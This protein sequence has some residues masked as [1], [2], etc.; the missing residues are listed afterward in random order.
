M[1]RNEFQTPNK[2][3]PIAWLV[4]ILVGILL[5]VISQDPLLVFISVL[6]LPIIFYFSFRDNEPQVIFIAFIFYYLSITI[7]L[8]Y[9]IYFN[10]SFTLYS[11]STLIESTTYISFVAMF[12]FMLGVYISTK[13]IKFKKND[14]ISTTLLKYNPSRIVIIYLSSFLLSSFIRINGSGWGGYY[15][16]AVNITYLHYAILFV[17][18]AH[19]YYTDSNTKITIA[20]VLFEIILSF[21]GYFSG[22]KDYLLIILA[23]LLAFKIQF[24]FRQT[25]LIT[26]ISFLTLYTLII[27][28]AVKPE[29]RK[30]LNG[31]EKS[32]TV[33]VSKSDALGK[34][35]ELASNFNSKNYNYEEIYYLLV[36]RISYTEFF[37]LSMEQVPQFI[38]HEN[39]QL[40]LDAFD[41]VLTPRILNPNKKAINDSEMVNK[42]SGKRV[43]G[44][45]EG[46]SFSLGIVAEMYIDFGIYLMHPILFLFGV[47][48]GFMYRY[49]IMNSLNK[50]WGCALVM[51]FLFLFNCNGVATK[52]VVGYLL[53]YFIVY[54]CFRF[55]LLKRIDKYLRGSYIKHL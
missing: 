11:E 12:F 22:F 39:G 32:Q 51:N 8:F 50:L 54:L 19:A 40:L 37:S 34:L 7:K 10:T 33:V 17:L 48:M 43:S 6:F 52:K 49:I 20:I 25:I 30:F 55:F 4:A 3:H 53:M 31:D 42:Y 47:F 13:K 26:I 21:S 36:D 15:Q 38:P 23:S 2:V 24:N 46:T 44:E 41:H 45:E 1:L 18:I 16:F 29:Y 35:L 28:T 27:W 9:A 5:G 14:S